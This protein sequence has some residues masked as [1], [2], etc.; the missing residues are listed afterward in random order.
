MKKKSSSIDDDIIDLTI[1]F[2]Y[3]WDGKI[4]IFIITL[5]SIFLGY[6]YYNQIPDSFKSSL[7]I[8]QNFKSEFFK[9]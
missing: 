2:K 5:I 6:G 8:K 9:I 3:I 7:V 4:K 1:I